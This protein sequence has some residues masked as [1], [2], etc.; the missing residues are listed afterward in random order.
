MGLLFDAEAISSAEVDDIRK[1]KQ[2]V[3]PQVPKKLI[4]EV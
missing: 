3:G 2:T 4:D 1:H